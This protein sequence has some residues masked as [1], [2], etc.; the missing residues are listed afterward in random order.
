MVRV[1]CGE[2]KEVGGSPLSMGNPAAPGLWLKQAPW[3]SWSHQA[4]GR[5][6]GAGN[7]GWKSYPS[8]RG[9]IIMGKS[10]TP[11]FRMDKRQVY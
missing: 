1:Q 5:Q 7:P 11:D 3:A 2:V 6:L 8:S 4:R 10:P 9:G